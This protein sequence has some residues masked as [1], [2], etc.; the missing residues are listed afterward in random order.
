MVILIA[1][2]SQ[3]RNIT[4]GVPQGSILRQLF[5]II[6]INDIAKANKLFNFIIYAC[7]TPLEITIE[8]VILESNNTSIEENIYFEL[9][10]IKQWL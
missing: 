10:L 3:V 4:T 1:Q 8:I 9:H 5:F 6:Y 7:D 2:T